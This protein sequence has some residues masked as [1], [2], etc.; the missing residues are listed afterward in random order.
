MGNTKITPATKEFTLQ[1]KTNKLQ[2]TV[3][4]E[5]YARTQDFQALG[6]P[7]SGWV[8]Q[9]RLCEGQKD[10]GARSGS[11][12]PALEAVC[13][14]KKQKKSNLSFLPNLRISR[15]WVKLLFCPRP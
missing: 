9:G 13:F 8:F 1:K 11:L 2:N 3:W 14:K 7:S 10:K 15:Y 12:N 5:L 6:G 4:K